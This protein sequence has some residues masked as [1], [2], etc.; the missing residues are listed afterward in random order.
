[1][2]GVGV[3]FALEPLRPFLPP[4]GLPRPKK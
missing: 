2:G 4:F 1:V 3:G